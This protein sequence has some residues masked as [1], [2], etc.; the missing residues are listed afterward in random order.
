MVAESVAKAAS[1]FS[2]AIGVGFGVGLALS[3]LGCATQLRYSTEAL[4]A[5]A[6]NAGIVD[7]C[8]KLPMVTEDYGVVAAY[9]ED[10]R[11]V[12]T[13]RNW[14]KFTA[15]AAKE[16]EFLYRYE[17][18]LPDE[19][20]ELFPEPYKKL[21]CRA[22]PSSKEV[23]VP[24]DLQRI[25]M[26]PVM[27][28]AMV[29]ILL[30]ER[31]RVPVVENN[32]SASLAGKRFLGQL[33]PAGLGPRAIYSPEAV[34]DVG[35][36]L[37]DAIRN[38]VPTVHNDANEAISILDT[39]EMQVVGG[40]AAGAGIGIVPGGWLVST[41]LQ[42]SPNGPKPTR[43]FSAGQA[44]GEMGSGALQMFIGGGGTIGGIG[45]SGSGGGALLGVPMCTAGVALAA[46]GATTFLHGATTLVITICHWN[47]LPKAADAQ[48]LA[49][50]AP[51]DAAGPPAPPPASPAPAPAPVKP[52]AAPVAA[53]VKPV[54]A[55]V[56]PAPA[57]PAPAKAPPP[58]KPTDPTV[59]RIKPSGTT[60]TERTRLKPGQTPSDTT[61]TIHT[62]EAGN[63]ISNTTTKTPSATTATTQAHHP[64]P[65]YLGGPAKQDLANLPESVH[66]SYHTGLDKILPRQRGTAYY[67]N[68]NPQAKQQ[69][70]RDLAAYTKAFDA[71]Y[72]THLFGSMIR[73]GF[74]GAP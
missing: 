2:R 30:D 25:R 38:G 9:D 54:A 34:D 39:R 8:M 63:V 42:A 73:N 4:H 49:A 70:I 65:K 74:P 61:I 45:L 66:K 5:M 58:A 15:F 32:E 1:W 22:E 48:P 6:P 28:D 14:K 27:R 53:P 71:K 59:V 68:L 62:D 69:L 10:T 24:V 23:P 72:G 13:D 11:T 12:V 44:L 67:D 46:N 36:M 19:T 57:K 43:E 20:T 37:R 3:S 35:Q 64:W 51:E 33:T 55:P 60:T 16:A 47:D 31:L 56:K 40:L 21:S 29:A 26:T 18:S 17:P 50:V 52:A 41:A 7:V